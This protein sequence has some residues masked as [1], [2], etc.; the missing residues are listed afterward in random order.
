MSSAISKCSISKSHWKQ[1]PH[2]VI[3]SLLFHHKLYLLF[4]W[5]C[6]LLCT[7]KK[8]SSCK[9]FGVFLDASLLV[10]R[11]QKMGLLFL[12]T[13]TPLAPSLIS[14]CLIISIYSFSQ[15]TST[16]F[17]FSQLLYSFYTTMS[18]PTIAVNVLNVAAFAPEDGV[19]KHFICPLTN[20]VMKH[21]VVTKEGHCFERSA[22]MGWMMQ[23][24]CKMEHLSDLSTNWSLRNEIRS[25]KLTNSQ[26]S[27]MSDC[28]SR[29]IS[30]ETNEAEGEM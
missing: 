24:G 27:L 10:P 25:W 20:Q 16:F 18:K 9:K 26:R 8:C 3:D 28:S 21:P 11:R 22:I 6:L 29:T 15:E 13:T 1:A 14:S 7:N 17:S 30:T 4:V 2:L 23:R 19:P 12:L 5:Y